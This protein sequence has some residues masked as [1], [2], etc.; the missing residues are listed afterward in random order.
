[1]HLDAR[2]RLQKS[3]ENCVVTVRSVS[4][5][6]RRFRGRSETLDQ[7]ADHSS[8][9]GDRAK[10]GLIY[11]IESIVTFRQCTLDVVLEGY[12]CVVVELIGILVLRDTAQ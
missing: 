11:S 9:L 6:A 1:M 7:A 8:V 12:V 5:I 10:N 3:G 2:C 4:E